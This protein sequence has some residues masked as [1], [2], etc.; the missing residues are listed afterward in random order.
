MRDHHLT[1]RSGRND[2][3]NT[4]ETPAWLLQML[5]AF[6]D[7]TMDACALPEGMKA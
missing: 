4:W 2:P 6:F 3:G 5:D 1:L 7:F